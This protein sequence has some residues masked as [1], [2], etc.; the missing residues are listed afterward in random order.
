MNIRQRIGRNM[1]TSAA[2]VAL[3]LLAFAF[4]AHDVL[5]QV[6][7][8]GGDIDI[9]IDDGDSYCELCGVGQVRVRVGYA[10]D[11]NSPITN[12]RISEDLSAPGLVPIPGTTVVD[13][14]NGATPPAP[15]H[16]CWRRVDLGL[17]RLP[18]R[19]GRQHA[20][21]W[22]VSRDHI[23]S[24]TCQRC[25]GRRAIQREQGDQCLGRIQRGR[26]GHGL[27]RCRMIS[28]R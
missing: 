5:A 2:R 9:T 26:L 19:A 21:Q 7:P 1:L 15:V 24:S 6:C 12:I 25:V 23:S 16:Q 22:P 20:E 18:A 28:R 4:P 10:D 17:R 3:A 13:V 8:P 14:G 11:D 27:L